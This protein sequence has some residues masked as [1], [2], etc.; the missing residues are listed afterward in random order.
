MIKRDVIIQVERT[1]WKFIIL[2]KDKNTFFK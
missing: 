1:L 2:L